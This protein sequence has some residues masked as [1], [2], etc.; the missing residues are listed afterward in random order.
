MTA[1]TKATLKGKFETGD[2]PT[3]S[4]YTDLIDSALNTADTTA[5]TLSSDLTVPVLTATTVTA[6]QV[7]T[8]GLSATRALLTTVT[9]NQVMASGVHAT[10]VS[11]A[12][13]GV[14]TLTGT[15]VC[16]ATIFVG[17]T[18]NISTATTASATGGVQG[19]GIGVVPTTAMGYI[20]VH[21]S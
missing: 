5:Q 18:F 12:S 7:N 19:A 11:G 6:N 17:A 1:Q 2:T 9:A 20:I 4:D 16:A 14:G 3:G 15:V 8:S 21:R 10:R 13:M